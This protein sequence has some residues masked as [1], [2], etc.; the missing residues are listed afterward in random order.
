MKR[1]QLNQ[2][3]MNL[4]LLIRTTVYREL[5]DLQKGMVGNVRWFFMRKMAR[6]NTCQ[7]LV[8]SFRRNT[9][10]LS[11]ISNHATIANSIFVDVDINQVVTQLEKDGIYVGLNL[12]KHLVNEIVKFAHHTP[13][14]AN[15]CEDLGFY[16][17]D[18][19]KVLKETGINLIIG[20]YYNTSSCEAIQKI[21]NDP[22]LTEI[23]RRYFN[24]DSVCQG[25]KLWWSFPTNLEIHHR[26]KYGQTFHYDLDD[27]AALKF[28]FYLTDVRAT[29]GPH[30]CVLGSH[31]SKAFLHN[32]LR[33][34]WSDDTI[35]RK[36]KKEHIKTIHAR[37]GEGFVEDTL[38]LHKGT[39]PEHKERLILVIE[40]AMRDYGMQN[41]I[42][43][44]NQL[45]LITYS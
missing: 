29:S 42:K 32:I 45:K 24:N 28:F 2:S 37:S 36:Y 15:G 43:N 1:L 16:Y 10:T 6:F 11:E 14:Y 4:I 20:D 31:N 21:T 23:S 17:H 18:K 39:I 30:V 13:C 25:H 3:L 8:K 33:G 12:P 7:Y 38:C 19:D 41:N 40:Y 27:Y 9:Y 22:V 5:S 34:Y 26:F 44:E 35:I